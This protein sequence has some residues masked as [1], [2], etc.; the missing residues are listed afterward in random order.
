[1]WA[2]LFVSHDSVTAKSVRAGLLLSLVSGNTNEL[3]TGD[4][5]PSVSFLLLTPQIA[6]GVLP[7]HHRPCLAGLSFT[8][9]E[10]Q[11]PFL[12]FRLSDSKAQCASMAHPLLRW[13]RYVD[14]NRKDEPA[15]RA[16]FHSFFIGL[17]RPHRRRWV[18]YL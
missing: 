3:P 5:S 7:M 17:S 11:I 1:M 12:S 8:L 18:Y 13:P 4:H 16:G 10:Q 6:C 9:R 2:F 15:E 14:S